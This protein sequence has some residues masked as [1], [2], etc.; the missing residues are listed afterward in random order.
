MNKPV[1][2]ETDRTGIIHS[3][4]GSWETFASENGGDAL[5]AKAVIGRP[6]LAFMSDST[7]REIYE[8]LM[9]RTLEGHAS[10]V[11]FRCDSS[12]RRRWMR[13]EMAPSASGLCFAV[14]IEREEARPP[15][16]LLEPSRVAGHGLITLCSWCKRVAVKQGWLEVEAAVEALNLFE[17]TAL[18]AISH[19]ICPTCFAQLEREAA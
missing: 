7:T 15:V 12:D 13:L 16:R 9:N 6:L 17:R 5:T 4:G 11:R 2:Y 10:T 19:G 1:R 8:R 18:P 14:H 3:V